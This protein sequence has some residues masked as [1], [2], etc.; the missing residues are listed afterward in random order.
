MVVTEISSMLCAMSR[1][2]ADLIDHENAIL[3][4]VASGLVPSSEE[5][6]DVPGCMLS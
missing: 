3:G 2:A 6:H 1:L 4:G 5:Q